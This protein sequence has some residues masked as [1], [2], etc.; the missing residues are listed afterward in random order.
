MSDNELERFFREE[1]YTEVAETLAFFL[2]EAGSDEAPDAA[3]ARRWQQLFAARG[4]R[5]A[6]LAENCARYAEETGDAAQ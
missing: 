1:A 4:G 6:K 3:E 5:F 2:E